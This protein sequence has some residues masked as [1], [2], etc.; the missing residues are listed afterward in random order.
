M[1]PTVAELVCELLP[2]GA[3]HRLSAT[4]R[5]LRFHLVRAELS[6]R[7]LAVTATHLARNGARAIVA[8]ARCR[9]CGKKRKCTTSRFPDTTTCLAC[10]TD[11]RGYRFHPTREQAAWI[12][13][14]TM[15]W[16]IKKRRLSEL[17]TR[18]LTPT[19]KH[20]VSLHDLR[21]L[22]AAQGFGAA[23][24]VVWRES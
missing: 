4:C 13:L 5:E 3:V 12:F 18:M 20:L 2:I 8:R 21:L 14:H 24:L 1:D 17:P 10:A 15:G 7:K 16:A 22:I 9:E 6:A 23:T 11:P 19:R